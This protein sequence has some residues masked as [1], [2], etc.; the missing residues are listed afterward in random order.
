VAPW[1]CLFASPY[2]L[3]LATYY[4]TTFGNPAFAKY[5]TEWK[6]PAF[7]SLWGV[8]FFTTAFFT[9][10]VVARRAKDFNLFE[11]GTLALTLVGGLMAVRSVIWFVY[12]VL[13]LLPAPLER[14]WPV[15]TRPDEQSVPFRAAL[16]TAAIG[17][18]LFLVFRPAHGIVPQWPPAAGR[19]V[20]RAAAADPSLRVFSNE[21]Y[22]DWLLFEQPSLKGRLAFDGRWEILPSTQMTRVIHFLHQET[23]TW[24]QPTAGYRLLVLDPKTNRRLTRTYSHRPGV[25][26]IYRDRRVVVFERS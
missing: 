8:I 21:E 25:R 6:P 9:V 15:R 18:C 20:A 1:L 16:S 3:S 2:G 26:V 13:V 12:A 7:N 24:E 23:A 11:L 22:A 4:R 17:A 14:L 10:A 5:I 19:A